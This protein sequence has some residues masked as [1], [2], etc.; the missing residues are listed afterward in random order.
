MADRCCKNSRIPDTPTRE[1]APARR[2]P[3]SSPPNG[4]EL[5]DNMQGLLLVVVFHFFELGV[6][7]V[8]VLGF[9]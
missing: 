5:A 6:N 7:H 2:H 3:T 1:Q 9:R 4:G 8:I